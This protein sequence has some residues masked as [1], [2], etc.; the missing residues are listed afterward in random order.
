[1]PYPHIAR[2]VTIGGIILMA[3]GAV[4]LRVEETNQKILALL[5]LEQ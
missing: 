4:M 5:Q 1:M 2:D 3:D